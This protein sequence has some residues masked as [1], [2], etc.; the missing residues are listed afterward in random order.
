MAIRQAFQ[1]TDAYAQPKSY[2]V[3]YVLNKI[4][5]LFYYALNPLTLLY[6]EA[7]NNSFQVAQKSA[8][9]AGPEPACLFF[10]V[11]HMW[12]TRR[13]WVKVNQHF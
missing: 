4:F 1:L 6:F 12:D 11:S 3:F 10:W 8:C 5:L 13:K 2:F 9:G 7:E